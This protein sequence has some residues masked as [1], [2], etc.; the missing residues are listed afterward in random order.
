M[1][2]VAPGRIGLYSQ[3]PHCPTLLASAEG[4]AEREGLS[5][6]KRRSETT[7][8]AGSSQQP[9]FSGFWSHLCT[10]LHSFTFVCS[11]VCVC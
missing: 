10:P 11:I 7:Q 2:R 8:R 5:S 4:G 1:G 6:H 9:P 3:T